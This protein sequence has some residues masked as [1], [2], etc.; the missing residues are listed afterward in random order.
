MSSWASCFIV[1][2]K[3]G[4]CFRNAFPYCLVKMARHPDPCP[5]TGSPVPSFISLSWLITSFFDPFL[6]PR[7][8]SSAQEVKPCFLLSTA[9][10]ASRT[11]PD[12]HWTASSYL[13]ILC[14]LSVVDTNDRFLRKITIGQANTEKGCSRQVR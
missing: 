10:P 7:M 13:L 8:G 4:H 5:N 12:T 2:K 9:S 14:S 3:K 6:C 1:K 11:T